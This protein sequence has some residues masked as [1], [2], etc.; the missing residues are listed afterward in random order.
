LKNTVVGSNRWRTFGEAKCL[1]VRKSAYSAR[2][3]A[4]SDVYMRTDVSLTGGQQYVV[5]FASRG[6]A[7][8][9]LLQFAW[10]YVTGAVGSAT[11]QVTDNDGVPQPIANVPV[12]GMFASVVRES[13]PPNVSEVVIT[14]GAGGF[15]GEVHIDLLNSTN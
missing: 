3:F 11:A 9:G 1:L 6:V 14:A 7:E 15:R 13:Q 8:A 10:L 4:G 2:E 12:P 5:R